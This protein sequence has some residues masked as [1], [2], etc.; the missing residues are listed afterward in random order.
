MLNKN[1]FIMLLLCL[2][3][4]FISFCARAEN[5]KETEHTKIEIFA[6]KNNEYIARLSLQD[7]WHIYWSNP[8]EIGK[9]T[10]VLPAGNWQII[11]QTA[12]EIS[13]PFA[14]ME[15]YIYKDSAYFYLRR[16]SPENP[17]LT[18]SFV[19]CS[20]SCKEENV[21]FNV[22]AL[23]PAAPHI[24]NHVY[25]DMQKKLPQMLTIHSLPETG[26]AETE[27]PFSSDI[28]FIPAQADTVTPDTLGI[29][30]NS[31]RA[32]FR[33]QNY[34]DRLLTKVLI[35]TP[36]VSYAAEIIYDGNFAGRGLVYILLLAFFAGILL[37]A[38]PCVFP[39]LSLKLLSLLKNKESYGHIRNA[40]LYTL[41]VLLSFWLLTALLLFLKQRGIAAGWGFQLQ[42]PLFTGVMSVIFLVLS[43]ALAEI[44]HFPAFVTDR[45]YKLSG[46]GQFS[47]G[48]FA[49]LIASPCTGPFMGAA[50]GYALMQGT[51]A[52]TFAVFTALALG[53]ALPCALLELY[54]SFMSRILPKPGK[55]MITVKYILAVPLL[56]TSVWLAGISYT[57][58][59]KNSVT[60]TDG[61]PVWLP[62]N[63][64]KIRIAAENGENIFIDFTADWCLTCKFNEKL[65]LNSKRF[66]NTVKEMKIHLYKADLTEDNPEYLRALNAYGRDSIP[67]YVYYRNGKYELLPLFFSISILKN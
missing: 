22:S 5:I 36:D 17:K 45:I 37:N 1:N 24:W 23:E 40:F 65:I 60:E 20:D 10:Q 48:F 14:D 66:K 44:I 53:Y 58:L 15:E 25:R 46:A 16:L 9:P 29:S 7:G 11:N 34:P 50:L 63:E 18:F 13:M 61:E 38:M 6:G 51:A 35:L 19:E 42:S 33:W 56:L 55:W 8:G 2:C 49:V 67:L 39:V 41:G 57:Q 27:L 4:L 64:E 3:V 43:L 47:S 59:S 54:P 31:G 12:P 21:S 62:Y 28:R 30:D 32:L 52:E 26:Y